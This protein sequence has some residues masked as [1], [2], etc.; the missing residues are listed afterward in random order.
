MCAAIGPLLAL[1]GAGY[2]ALTL[3]YTLVWRH[4]M[5]FDIFAVAGGSSCCARCAAGSQR[6][7]GLSSCSY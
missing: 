3:S 7:S 5:V 2:V 4:L 6:P 1:V